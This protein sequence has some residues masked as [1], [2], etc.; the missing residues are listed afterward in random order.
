M[1]PTSITLS[2]DHGVYAREETMR[3]RTTLNRRESLVSALSVGLCAGL[4]SATNGAQAQQAGGRSRVLVA[5]LS[6]SGNTRVVAV[7]FA[8]LLAQICSKSNRHNRTPRTTKRPCARQSASGSPD[9][10]HR[11]RRR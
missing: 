7:T 10:S 9:S 6:R 11:S 4:V 3:Q 1:I 8:V 5:Y 2:G